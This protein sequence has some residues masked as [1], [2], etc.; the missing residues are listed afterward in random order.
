MCHMSKRKQIFYEASQ[1][2]DRVVSQ[3]TMLWNKTGVKR[4]MRPVYR[5]LTPPCNNACP[6]GNDIEG[7]IRLA[8]KKDFFGALKLIKEE[9]PFS[10]ICGRVCFHSCENACNRGKYDH[11][12]AIHAIERFVSDH[13]MKDFKPQKLFSSSGKRVAVVGSGPAGLSC[14]YHLARFGHAVTVFE[15]NDKP[16]GILRYGIPAYRLPKDILD[17]EIADIVGLGVE[18]DCKTTI[19]KDI[20]WNKLNEFDAVFI[21]T[22]CYKEKQIFDVKKGVKGFFS[23]LSYLRKTVKKEL[24]KSGR[25]TAVIGGD[26]AAIACA[27]TALRFG[28]SVTLFYQGTQDK[29]P[30]FEEDILDAQKEGV[31]FQFL[32]H[33]VDLI[34][35][36]GKI[37]ELKLQKI[38]LGNPDSTGRK[39]MEPVPGSEFSFKTDMVI[40]AMDKTADF[41]LMPQSLNPDSSNNDLLKIK[42]DEFGRTSLEKIFAGGCAA[43]NEY[44]IDEY[45]IAEAIGS[46][47]STACAIDASLSGQDINE[48]KDQIC[49][50]NTQRVSAIRYCAVKSVAK[51]QNILK[52]VVL[53]EDINTAYFDRKARSGEEKLNVQERLKGFDEVC[54]SLSLSSALAETERCFHCGVCMECDNCVKFCPDMSVIKREKASGYDIDLDYCKGCGICVNECPRSAMTMEKEI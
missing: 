12:V 25:I 16:G 49:I 41:D 3:G 39:S 22:G 44:N 21:A 46:G 34:V 48:I 2:P 53:F 35:K 37:K 14:A 51:P 20:S 6:A 54:K 31:E 13:G 40:T 18:I 5:R 52:S 42:I 36:W 50:G 23:S 38:T 30:A 9:N 4:Y 45:N 10:G 11:S 7:F 27:R 8:E 32:V 26:N 19:G 15:K 1:V 17:H 29:M 28:S 47:K 24:K 33:P 43:S